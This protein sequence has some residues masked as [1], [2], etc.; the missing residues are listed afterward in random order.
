[1]KILQ[2]SISLS[3]CALAIGFV[4]CS[5]GTTNSVDPGVDSGIDPGLDAGTD[6]TTPGATYAVGGT[7]SGLTGSGLVLDNGG[8][9]VTLSKTDTT[10]KFSKKLAKGATYS[11]N[12]KTQPDGPSQTC[13]VTAGDGT[14]AAADVTSIKVTCATNQYPISVTVKGLEGAG[15]VLQNNAGDDLAVSPVSPLAD[16]KASFKTKIDSGKPFA[17]SVKT[18]PTTPNQLC[19]VSGDKGTVVSGEVSSIVV[20]CTKSYTIGGTITGLTGKNLVIQNNAGDDLPVNSNGSFAFPKT[21]LK[22]DAYAVTV[23]T[24]PT[25]PW[26]TCTVTAG[27][28]TVASADVT[29]VAI[30]CAPNKYAISGTIT[31]LT[32]TGATIQNNGADDI[33]LAANAATFA[34]PAKVD[35][36][37]TYTVSVKTQPSAP[38]QTCTVT[39]NAGPTKVAGADISNV[40][41]TCATNKYKVNVK[42]TG[43]TGTVVLQNNAVEDLTVNADGTTAF[44]TSIES[45]RPYAVTIK[46]KSNV[47]SETC[48]LQAPTSGT[49]GGADLTIALNCAKYTTLTGV[50]DPATVLNPIAVTFSYPNNIINGI[51]HKPSNLIIVGDYTSR[52]Y[53]SHSASAGG[54]PSAPNNDTG[55]LYSKFVQMPATS[56]VVRVGGYLPANYNEIYIGNI[57]AVT[58]AIGGFVV[59]TYSDGFTGKCNLISS[60]ASEFLCYDGAN[61]RIYS[62]AVGSAILT[63]VKSVAIAPAY[64]GAGGSFSGTFGWDGMYYYFSSN[65]TSPNNLAYQAFRA[66][67]SLQGNYV[68]TG[69]GSINGVYFDWSVG[70]YAI[71][72]GYGGRTG[73]TRYYSAAG[74][75]GDSD[76]QAYSPVSAAHLVP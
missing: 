25:D 51:W 46:T 10:F 54:Y 24:Q 64:N 41:I 45:G 14:V 31:G 17:I 16:V 73:G 20:N 15:L 55:V 44:A 9:T 66:D 49:V 74:V 11:I 34:F 4:A 60:S 12:V 36:G 21:A 29:A 65:G 18:Q 58:G 62:T 8:D 48:T 38:T 56:K 50:P 33:V 47:A 19:V 40:A 6:A 35:S 61:I 76:T 39:A 63:F 43:I 5:D 2:F 3:I 68:A 32:G 70:R 13:T 26:Q 27:T 59:P 30:V 52:G 23:K 71:H 7:V 1:M 37:A 42:T 69:P 67:G 72:D 75:N 53:W 22:G 28:G 57:D